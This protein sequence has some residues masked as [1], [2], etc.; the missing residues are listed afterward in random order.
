MILKLDEIIQKL[1][2][3]NLDGKI[4]DERFKKL[5]ATYEA[6]QKE[7]ES[8]VRELKEQ[9]A[10]AKEAALN[11]DYFLKIV[12]KYTDAKELTAEMIREFV[13]RIIVF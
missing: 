13:E 12:K 2:E 10:A 7:L 11:V 1:Y 9:T 3:D 8:R 6:E 4:T 5:T